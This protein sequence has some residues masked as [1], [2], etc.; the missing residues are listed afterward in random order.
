MEAL[1]ELGA[2]PSLRTGPDVWS[3]W[4]RPGYNALDCAVWS[5]VWNN[6]EGG[7][8][9]E[10]LIRA[11][12]KVNQHDG[13]GKTPLHHAV[14]EMHLDAIRV[15][16]KAGADINA[17]DKKFVRK[18]SI[19]YSDIPPPQ[20]RH[21]IGG[22]HY[23]QTSLFTAIRSDFP[24]QGD[25][26]YRM[27]LLTQ[28]REVVK[29]LLDKGATTAA[30]LPDGAAP[31]HIAMLHAQPKEI[32]EL[33]LTHGADI[34]AKDNELATALHYAASRRWKEGTGWEGDRRQGA[35]KLDL[36]RMLVGKGASRTARTKGKNLT[37]L[38]WA[39][40][41]YGFSDPETSIGKEIIKILKDTAAAE[42]RAIQP[43]T[44]FYPRAPGR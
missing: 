12:V 24:Q 10:T 29:L 8:L 31:L 3:L 1:L 37:P 14:A 23:G 40:R 4:N 16:L 35:V 25:K 44:G 17:A 39:E 43:R 26:K 27:Q 30:K 15:L 33:L 42:R 18:N 41:P 9:V 34:N 20:Y 38:E 11:G 6:R 13:T 5:G 28:R 7:K 2:N 32:A 36:V 19:P 21:K 22:V